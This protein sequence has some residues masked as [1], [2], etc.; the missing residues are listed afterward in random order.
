MKLLLLLAMFQL[1][2][3]VRKPAVSGGE[4]Y[5][6]LAYVLVIDPQGI[7]APQYSITRKDVG[8]LSYGAAFSK[9]LAV[10][11]E[12]WLDGSELYPAHTIQKVWLY[13][14]CPG[15]ELE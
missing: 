5:Y 3:P 1:H 10:G 13:Y 7:P 4:G 11:K 15:C 6:V 14:R 9:L 12:G 8:P 2:T